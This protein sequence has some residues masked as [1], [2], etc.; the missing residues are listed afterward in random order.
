MTDTIEIIISVSR[1]ALPLLGVIVVGVCA[2]WLLR[3]RPQAPPEAFLLNAVNH[4][5]LPL[6]RW[7]S[8]LGRSKH[9]DVVLNYGSVS[10][11]HAVIARRRQGWVIIDTGSKGGT[12]LNGQPVE[13]R[14]PLSSGQRVAFGAH[15]FL[16]YDAEEERA[17]GINSAFSIHNSAL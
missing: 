3:Q 7:E 13:G 15:E 2:L 5:K 16:F 11:F 4:D 12:K 6:A 10:R 1:F 9:C 8:S 14:A 17:E